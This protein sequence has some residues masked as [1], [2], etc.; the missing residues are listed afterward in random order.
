[1]NKEYLEKMFD[2]EFFNLEQHWNWKYEYVDSELKQFIFE[3]IIPEVLNNIWEELF[4]LDFQF[5]KE[6]ISRNEYVERL[7]Q[8][9][10]ELYWIDL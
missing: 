1:M 2:K 7:K 9:A 4:W 5:W 8:K 6:S 3:I 10:K